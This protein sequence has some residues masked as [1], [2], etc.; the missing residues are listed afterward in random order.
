MF[1]FAGEIQKDGNAG[2]Y[3]Y[4]N[5]RFQAEKKTNSNGFIFSMRSNSVQFNL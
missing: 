4:N 1:S 5:K 2:V 3:L